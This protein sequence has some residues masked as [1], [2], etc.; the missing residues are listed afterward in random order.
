MF[1]RTATGPQ[2]SVHIFNSYLFKIRFNIVLPPPSMYRV[3]KCIFPSCFEAKLC[4]RFR[5]HVRATCPTQLFFYLFFSFYRCSAVACSSSDEASGTV[6]HFI[7]SWWNRPV[8]KTENLMIFMLLFWVLAP[9]RFVGRCQ[10]FGLKVETVCFYETLA[11]TYEYT[12][13]QKP[14]RITS[15]SSPP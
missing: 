9:C 7:D 3:P 2:N 5:S 10:R 12:R 1:T 15:S 4:K 11:S 14:R 8:N 6:N 13:R